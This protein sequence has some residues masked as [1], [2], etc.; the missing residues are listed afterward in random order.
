MYETYAKK[1]ALDPKVQKWMREV[2]PWAL[3]RIADVLL[4][5]EKRGLW[6]AKEET[7]KALSGL[8]LEIEGDLEAAADR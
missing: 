7:K 3:H 5:A 8:F 1:Y 2:N 4:E 6:N